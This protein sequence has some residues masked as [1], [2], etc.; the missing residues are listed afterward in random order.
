MMDKVVMKEKLEATIDLLQQLLADFT[1]EAETAEAAPA[2]KATK[3]KEAAPAKEATKAKGKAKPAPEPE[4]EEEAEEEEESLTLEDLQEMD[5]AGLKKVAAETELVMPKKVTK[6]TLLKAFEE[7]FFSEEEEDAAEEEEE[8]E[9]EEEV[10]EEP[11]PKTKGKA[12]AKPEPEQEPEEDEEDEEG[13]LTAEDINQMSLAE[14]KKLVK[15][16]ELEVPA[17][18][19]KNVNK[20][21]EALIELIEAE[22]EEEED[23][24]A[25]AERLEAE[26]EVE[27]QI[28]QQLKGKKLN[29]AKMKK[30]LADYQEGNPDCEDCGNCSTEE[31]TDCYIQTKQALVDD[32]GEVHEASDLYLRN[33]INHCCGAPLQ[34]DGTCAICGSEWE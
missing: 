14:L 8:E 19:L 32:E 33:G 7:Q 17:A 21:R 30:F 29:A 26:A 9:G 1:A 4:P 3:K 6:A 10:A 15:E 28:R 34:E 27:A 24:E 13:V 18:A 31:L 2:K 11:A 20:L 23:F 22:D 16:N 5:L 25:S 12:K